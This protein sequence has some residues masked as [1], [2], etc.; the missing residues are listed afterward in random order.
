MLYRDKAW[1]VEQH[2]DNGLSQREMAEIA[3]C[4]DVCISQWMKRYHIPVRD[5]HPEYDDTLHD[6]DWVEKRYVQDGWS[7]Q[8]IAGFVGCSSS[9]ARLWVHKHS[10]PIRGFGHGA[11]SIDQD[12]LY[13]QYVVQQRSAVE[14]AG[15]SGC[16]VWV[17]I[18]RLARCGI[19][20]RGKDEAMSI[21]HQHQRGTY[22]TPAYRERLSATKLGELNPSWKGGV[23]PERRAC[24]NSREY[25]AWR[26]QV[27]DRYDWQCVVCGQF[28]PVAHH[29]QSFCDNPDL[30]FEVGNG[31]AL[32]VDCHIAFHDEYGKGGNTRR[33]FD[34]FRDK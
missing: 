34:E 10:L 2:W 25:E 15:V 26:Q 6:R 7:V 16:S 20:Q 21:A 31:M 23:T 29:L 30:R 24:R 13:D 18:D 9:V 19:P 12:W 11:Y 28:A 3:G 1:L 5:P 8:Q 27:L 4:T 33:Q 14:I 22:G 17:V 32:C